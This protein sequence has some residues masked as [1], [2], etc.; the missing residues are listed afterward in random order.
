MQVTVLKINSL[1][2]KSCLG[3][4]TGISSGTGFGVTFDLSLKL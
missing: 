4:E 1:N 3:Y 2:L